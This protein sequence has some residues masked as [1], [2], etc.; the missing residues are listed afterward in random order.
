MTSSLSSVCSFALA[1]VVDLI[2]YPSHTFSTLIKGTLIAHIMNSSLI[3]SVAS[4]CAP[5]LFD[6]ACF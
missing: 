1:K 6:L 4:V 2:C 5:A 3:S